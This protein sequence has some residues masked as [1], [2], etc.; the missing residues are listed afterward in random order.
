VFVVDNRKEILGCRNYNCYLTLSPPTP[1]CDAGK[2][3]AEDEDEEEDG[4][5]AP[6]VFYTVVGTLSTP[7]AVA[8]KWV[9]EIVPVSVAVRLHLALASR[10]RSDGVR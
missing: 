5:G 8:P 7:D 2:I 10:S 6:K 1:V 3:G 4:G 9:K